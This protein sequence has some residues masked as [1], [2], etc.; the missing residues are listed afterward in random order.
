MEYDYTSLGVP[1]KL[2]TLIAEIER[3]IYRDPPRAMLLS[4]EALTIAQEHILRSEEAQILI[5]RAQI[6][7]KLSQFDRALLEAHQG[8]GLFEDINEAEGLSHAHRIT[9]TI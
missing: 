2:R 4:D 8:L 1:D 5:A 7:Q 6:S 9:G 3:T